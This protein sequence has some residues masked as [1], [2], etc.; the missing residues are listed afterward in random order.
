MLP[1]IAGADAPDGAMVSGARWGGLAQKEAADDKRHRDEMTKQML[2][3][4]LTK[5]ESLL[6]MQKGMN[7]A[8]QAKLT[9]LMK[10]CDERDQRVFTMRTAM[11]KVER[12]CSERIA[13]A[14][15]E[16]K[17]VLAGQKY[18]DMKDDLRRR[19]TLI[20]DKDS[21]VAKMEKKCFNLERKVGALTSQLN[22]SKEQTKEAEKQWNETVKDVESMK[23]KHSHA[24][25]KLREAKQSVRFLEV[26]LEERELEV[27]KLRV[28]VQMAEEDLVAAKREIRRQRDR[29]DRSESF[30]PRDMPG[31]TSAREEELE[32]ELV[33]THAR[34]AEQVSQMDDLMSL[35]QSLVSRAASSSRSS[36]TFD[37]QP[38]FS[39]EAEKLVA[40]EAEATQK[41]AELEKQVAAAENMASEARMENAARLQRL[42][43][44]VAQLQAKADSETEKRVAAEQQLEQLRALAPGTPQTAL[45]ART[46]EPEPEPEP[47]GVASSDI[48]AEM[49][50]MAETAPDLSGSE[51]ENSGFAPGH[52]A[53]DNLDEAAAASVKL[54]D[55][56]TKRLDKTN[57]QVRALT[58]KTPQTALLGT[59]TAPLRTASEEE[60]NAQMAELAARHAAELQEEFDAMSHLLTEQEKLELQKELLQLHHAMDP[61]EARKTL[62]KFD[63]D[64]DGKVSSAE[65]RAGLIDLE[66][67]KQSC[68]NDT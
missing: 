4:K 28:S 65:L 46:P 24:G 9:A 6:G 20:M 54:A 51:S 52:P 62:E 55:E 53:F 8:L 57:D 63:T 38:S 17:A 37:D 18:E 23:S 32:D 45:R 22:Q 47:H 29:A 48:S 7:S 11:Q 3:S 56:V 61:D 64:G 33:S 68:V 43:E 14:E 50:K 59:D 5:V 30:S 41:V 31:T 1:A 27:A 42:E 39:D 60:Q 12:E 44:R 26:Q 21:A 66:V 35:A 49:S 58:P 13:K 15:A 10:K 16:N 2:A 34:V 19:A 67:Q 40:A 25:I 36:V